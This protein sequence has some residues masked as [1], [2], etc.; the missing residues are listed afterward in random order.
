MSTQL[1][2]YNQALLKLGERALSSLTEERKSR[3]DLDTVWASGA[4]NFCLEQA[5]WYFAMRA[6][7]AD[8]DPDIS[9]AFGFAYAFGKPSDWVVTSAFCSDEYMQVP[10]NAYI[11][12]AG[13]WYCDYQT[14]YLKYVSDDTGY[15]GDM[16][17]WPA[18]FADYVSSYMASEIILST[19]Q[20]MD[21]YQK[22]C[23]LILN[24]ALITAKNKAA[25]TGPTQFPARGMW[26]KSRSSSDMS[27][28]GNRSSLYG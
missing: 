28:R 11:D 3:R 23:Q 2:I 24:P 13:Y 21:R 16:L 18:T 27:E 7:Q 4:V 26:S 6:I 15:G 1:T 17:K 14:I 19:T 20:S 22:F 25:M 8:Y 10:I 5:Q 12:E 9:P